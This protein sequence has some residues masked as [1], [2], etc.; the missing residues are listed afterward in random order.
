MRSLSFF[1][2]SMYMA[3]EL[4]SSSSSIACSFLIMNSIEGSDTL[5]AAKNIEFSF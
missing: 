4:P 5:R 1:E 3:A 2:K